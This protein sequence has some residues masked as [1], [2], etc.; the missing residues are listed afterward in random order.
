MQNMVS[1]SNHPRNPFNDITLILQFFLAKRTL[2]NW[3]WN[4][5]DKDASIVRITNFLICHLIFIRSF[6]AKT[7]KL[8]GLAAVTIHLSAPQKDAPVKPLTTSK[9]TSNMLAIGFP[10]GS[11]LPP[12]EFPQGNIRAKDS[13]LVRTIPTLL[14]LTPSLPA[15]PPRERS[16]KRR[17]SQYKPGTRSVVC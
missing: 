9:Y 14:R 7:L 16:D 2:M 12:L 11:R 8:E 17:R 15:R 10:L 4:K 3:K 6:I 5:F 13:V 1:R